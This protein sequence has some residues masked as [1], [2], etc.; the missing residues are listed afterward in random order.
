M[1]RGTIFAI[2][3]SMNY[4]RRG[5]SIEIFKMV[6]IQFTAWSPEKCTLCKAVAKQ[7]VDFFLGHSVYRQSI[8]ASHTILL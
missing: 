8:G 7:S 3:N 6:T 1:E 2:E 4:I 5:C